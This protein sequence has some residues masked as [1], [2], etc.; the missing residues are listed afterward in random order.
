MGAI[1]DAALE[2]ADAGYAVIPVRRS[3]KAPLTE[4]GLSDASKDASTIRAWWDRFPDANV[5]VVCGAASGN[6]VALDVDVKD[7][8]QGDFYIHSWQSEHG[9]FPETVVQI[10]GSGGMHF[11]FRCENLSEFKN[12]VEAIPGVD[13]RGDG[14]YVVVHPSVYADGRTYEWK[15]GVSL[16]DVDEVATANESVIELLSLNKRN[17]KSRSKVAS[18]S[19]RDVKAG[20]RNSTLFRYASAQR[21]YDV[22][23]DVCLS[24][25]EHLSAEWSQPL[26]DSEIRK[27]VDSAYRFEPDEANIYGEAPEPEPSGDDLTIPTLEEF[28]EKDVQWL[29]PGYIP[30]EQITLLC[31]TGGTGKTSIWVSL[32]AS[33]SSGSRTLFDGTSPDSFIQKQDPM[34]VMFFSGEDTVEHVIKKRLHAQKAT[35]R[36][37]VTV[38]MDDERFR[39]I[40]FGS[41]YLEKLIEKYRPAVC[42]FDP[43]QSFLDE[44]VD[45]AKRNS[46]RQ[47]MQYLIEW[48]KRYGTTFLIV[49]HTNKLQNAWGR[50]RIADSADLW[51]I[52]RCVLMVGDTEEK[53]L[54][55]LSHEKSNYGMTGQTILFK[56]EH[57][58][59]VFQSWSGLK[60]MDFVTSATKKR[61]EAK[62]SSDVEEAA[63]FILNTLGEYPD[64]LLSKELDEL[65][66]ETAGFKQWAVRK[67]K[68]L[69]SESKRIKYSKDSFDS[70]WKIT[71]IH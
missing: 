31:G 37:I 5:A 63:E 26:A 28:P 45:M 30:R 51:D 67:A 11:F 59:P 36:N 70:A 68:A 46:M 10:T 13:V 1:L 33:L 19:M 22:P 27:I 56:N 6:L 44:K 18:R 58:N 41:T 62:G 14:A 69:L 43:L 4:H 9:D 52:A 66:I 34:R 49:V 25:C 17:K 20:A 54:K 39:K 24:A 12:T 8:K 61:N 47:N 23:Y 60:D 71:K 38:S 21:R 29:V 42:V 48:G 55:Y 57:G 7:G 40:R 16:L 15:H 53:D 2:Y 35:M 64:G 3:D 65:A 32:L 50:N